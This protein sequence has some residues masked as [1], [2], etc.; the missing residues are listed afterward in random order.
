MHCQRLPDATA[1]ARHPLAAAAAQA[2][3]D[4]LA[5]SNTASAAMDE[6]MGVAVV[7]D[8]DDEDLS[9]VLSSIYSEVSTTFLC[10]KKKSIH[11]SLFILVIQDDLLNGFILDII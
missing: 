2:L 1:P 8:E 11:D 6:A 3:L 9:K 4:A 10:V 5:T 7:F